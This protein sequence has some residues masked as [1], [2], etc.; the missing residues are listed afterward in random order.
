MK[1]KISISLVILGFLSSINLNAADSFESWFSEGKAKGNIKY[2]YIQTDKDHANSPSTSAYA[3][4]IG[5]QLSYTTANWSGFSSGATFMTTN[6]FLLPDT[7]DTSILGRDNAVK[8]GLAAGDKVAQVPF[9]VLGEAF[10]NY[11]Y[12]DLNLLYGRKV[13]KT[14]LVNAK[15]VR[16]LPSAVEGAFAQYKLNKTN[17]IEVSYLTGFK[18]RTSNEFINI[19]KHALGDKTKEITGSSTGNLIYADYKFKTDDFS[20]KLYDYYSQNFLNSVYLDAKYASSLSDDME[21][22]ISGQYI[23]QMS[24]GNADTNLA[25]TGS[26]TGAKNIATNAFA[27][28][29]DIKYSQANF[30]LAYSKVVK[31]DNKHDGL[32]LPYDGTPLFTNMITSNNLFISNYGKGLTSDSVYI[33]GSQGIKLGYVQK[34]DFT[35]VKGFKTSMTYLNTQN[36]RFTRNQE[37]YNIVLAYAKNKFTLALKG[38]L[39][40]NNTSALADGTISQ[41]EKLTQYRVIANYKF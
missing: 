2:Y 7:V 35:G 4:T 41:I 40:N 1:K 32:V 29:A 24:V 30:S 10:I 17:S 9:S 16:L 13:I 23:N 39:V 34:Y 38:I 31:N 14:P 8:Q 27:L 18:Q 6:G 37:D 36:S 3:N 21:Y 33:G 12:E 25:K 20:L 28:K 15:V 22:A 19:T 5:G 26:V 11:K